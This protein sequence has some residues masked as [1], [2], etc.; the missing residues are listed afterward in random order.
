MADTR[1]GSTLL[2][3]L[4]CIAIIVILVSV[5]LPV[6]SRAY[7]WCYEWTLGS[8]YYKHDQI[9]VYLNDDAPQKWVE[10]Y[11]TNSVRRWKS[12]DG[13]RLWPTDLKE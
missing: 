4:V 11:S 5:I 12:Y 8:M 13:V 1:K 3:L 9:N 10:Y 6:V 7:L 2:E